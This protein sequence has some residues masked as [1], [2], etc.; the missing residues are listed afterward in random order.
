MHLAVALDGYGWHPQAWRRGLSHN[1]SGEGPLS[2]RYWADV[3]ATAERG[4]LDFVTFDDTWAPQ[5][6]RRPQIDPNRLAGRADAVLVAARVAPTTRHIG[7]VPVAT[8]T[9]TE[10]FHVSTS[11]A[12][13]DYISHGRAGWQPRVSAR[14]SRRREPR[15]AEH[16]GPV[17]DQHR[18]RC[19]DGI[20]QHRRTC[21]ARRAVG[22]QALLDRRA[23]LR[24]GGKLVACAAGRS[25]RRGHRTHQGRGRRRAAGPDHR[26]RGCRKLRDARRVLPRP[27]RPRCR[28]V[29][30]A[31]S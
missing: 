17:A 15:A 19:L 22:L 10:P 1:S 28:P 16:P 2:G 24:R 21:A 11:I 12:T 13:L 14:A 8:V 18:R 25:D 9:H 20:A 4:L 26:A 27:H 5:A 31:P 7:L 6:G 30:P 3:V 29:G 23:P